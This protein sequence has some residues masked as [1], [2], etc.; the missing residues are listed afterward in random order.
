[1]FFHE[2]SEKFWCIKEYESATNEGVFS[3][4]FSLA[5]AWLSAGC[6]EMCNKSDNRQRRD[7]RDGF[8]VSEQGGLVCSHA[9]VAI[10]SCHLRLS[11]VV[12]SLH[13]CNSPSLQEFLCSC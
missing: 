4:C 6:A 10:E 11:K 9:H 12:L 13:G 8:H 7:F 1:M 3:V 5:L 2:Y